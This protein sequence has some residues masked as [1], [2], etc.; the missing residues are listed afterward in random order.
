MGRGTAAW[1]WP[2]GMKDELLRR[3]SFGTSECHHLPSSSCANRT[4]V[5]LVLILVGRRFQELPCGLQEPSLQPLRAAAG[6][7]LIS[8]EG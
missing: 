3:G 5:R 2:E 4:L 6:L 1:V 8:P 7:D